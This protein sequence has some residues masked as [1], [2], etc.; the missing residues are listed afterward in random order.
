MELDFY[1]DPLRTQ[2]AAHRVTRAPEAV[3]KPKP[4]EIASDQDLRFGK[5]PTKF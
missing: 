5:W 4:R 2:G 3:T 1:D